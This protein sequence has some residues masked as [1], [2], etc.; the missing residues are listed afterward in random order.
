MN[1]SVNGTLIVN[2]NPPFIGFSNEDSSEFKNLSKSELTRFLIDIADGEPG[3]TLPKEFQARI[4]GDFSL[5]RLEEYG[6]LVNFNSLK[7]KN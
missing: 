7:R 5:Q 3:M 1:K 2:L 6:L 4:S